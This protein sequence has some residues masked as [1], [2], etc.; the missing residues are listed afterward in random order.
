M[1]RR[2]TR[3]AQAAEQVLDVA[4]IVIVCVEYYS[5]CPQR[6]KTPSAR[7]KTQKKDLARRRQSEH[8]FGRQEEEEQEKVVM[9]EGGE[10][11]GR[12]TNI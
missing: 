12:L 9:K 6:T 8:K 7:N 5:L 4:V 10:V 3:L 2:W 1:G 11:T